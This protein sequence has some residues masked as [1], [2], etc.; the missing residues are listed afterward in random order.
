LRRSSVTAKKGGKKI[1][2]TYY[3]NTGHTRQLGES[4]A[5]ELGCDSEEIVEKNS[6]GRL[7]AEG[8]E[9]SSAGS[10]MK[11]ALWTLLGRGS[12]IRQVQRDPSDYDLTLVGTPVWAGCV[13][14]PV[15]SYLKQHRGSFRKLAFFWTGGG[16]TNPRVF[17]QMAKTSGTAPVAVL[18]ISADTLGTDDY[19][20][21][22]REFAAQ[23]RVSLS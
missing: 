8:E 14:S 16:G 13:T 5:E 19:K 9:R 15:R 10:I 2:V 3:S 21:K 23:V 7:A 4:I 22:V 11:A 1:L 12:P 20:Q 6:R 18:G 17:K